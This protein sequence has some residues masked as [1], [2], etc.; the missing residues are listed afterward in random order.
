MKQILILAVFLIGVV[1][2]AQ[3]EVALGVVLGDPTGFSGRF[4]LDKSHS[5]STAL[6]FSS[7]RHERLHFNLN[8]LWDNARVFATSGGGPLGMYY[9]LGA[10]LIAI[11]GGRHDGEVAFA[12][13]APLGLLYKFTNPNLEV[14]A[15]LA[16]NLEVV[17]EMDVDL[18]A[19]IGVR[20]RF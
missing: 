15:E 4:S 5:V 11:D 16:V 9:G 13:R 2:S 20:I 14:F 3:A 6:A 7:R 12:P 10:R 18:D 19:G 8:Y 17:P 1:S